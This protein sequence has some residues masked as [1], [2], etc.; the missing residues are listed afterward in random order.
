MKK[1]RIRTECEAPRWAN[2]P[3]FIRGLA[4]KLEM[5]C[6]VTV[7]KGWIRETIRFEVR[8]NEDQLKQ[9]KETFNRTTNEYNS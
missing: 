2:V 7:E 5:E 9:F 1:G 3:S 6:D 4:W 8:G